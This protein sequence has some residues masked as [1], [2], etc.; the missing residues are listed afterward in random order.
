MSENSKTNILKK[1]RDA[2]INKTN[3]PYPQISDVFVFEKST[4]NLTELLI[5]NLQQLDVNCFLFKNE[6]ELKT[7]LQNIIQTKNISAVNFENHYFQNFFSELEIF[8]N[9]DKSG[10]SANITGCNRLIAKSGTIL[11]S[12]QNGRL[13][14]IA[15]DIHIVIA[16]NEQIVYNIND[17]IQA[18]DCSDIPSMLCFISG[19]SR[20]ADIEKTLVMGAHGPKE[21]YVFLGNLKN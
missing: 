3:R 9:S 4:V 10:N 17:A 11:I 18:V 8:N 15:P 19:A 13:Q 20:T 16:S 2:L 14:S 7:L 5:Q 21:L 12:S 6:L 1:I